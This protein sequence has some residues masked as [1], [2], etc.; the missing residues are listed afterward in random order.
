MNIDYCG[1]WIPRKYKFRIMS[2]ACIVFHSLNVDTLETRALKHMRT[3]DEQCNCY[4]CYSKL[5][6]LF[7][8][9]NKTLISD[10][11]NENWLVHFPPPFVHR[12][13]HIF[14]NVLKCNNNNRCKE[15][16]DKKV[17]GWNVVAACKMLSLCSSTLPRKYHPLKS[18]PYTRLRIFIRSAFVTNIK[19]TCLRSNFIS[20]Y[21]SSFMKNTNLMSLR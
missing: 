2:C 10:E 16:L 4:L 21:L 7:P 20:L 1:L 14:I 17:V 11:M 13:I 15:K 12:F 18:L 8:N 3:W 6:C 19:H 5:W 9:S